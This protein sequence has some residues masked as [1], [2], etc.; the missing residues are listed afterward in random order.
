MRLDPIYLV[1]PKPNPPSMPTRRAFLVAGATFTLGAAVGG[2]C[3]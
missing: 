1:A 2:A 3:G